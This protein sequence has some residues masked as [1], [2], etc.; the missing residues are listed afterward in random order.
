MPNEPKT[1]WRP[2]VERRIEIW[3]PELLKDSIRRSCIEDRPGVCAWEDLPSE[4]QLGT[5]AQKATTCLRA[6]E[7]DPEHYERAAVIQWEPV[8]K[9][10]MITKDT[11]LQIG[12]Y[13]GVL[14]ISPR[15]QVGERTSQEI[16][17]IHSHHTREGF[18]ARDVANFLSFSDSKIHI[19]ASGGDDISLLIASRETSWLKHDNTEESIQKA[20]DKKADIWERL[21]I[22]F[23]NQIVNSPELA[24]RWTFNAQYKETVVIN[25]VNDFFANVSAKYKFGYYRGDASRVS[26]VLPKQ[27]N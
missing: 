19:L 26:R 22:K 3:T 11:N 23:R 16:G 9:I 14:V 13:N 1:P 25:I 5:F 6:T 12:D 21:Q 15:Y 7:S 2:D 10:I 24:Y 27:S 8:R 20:M 4:I 17:V 18:S